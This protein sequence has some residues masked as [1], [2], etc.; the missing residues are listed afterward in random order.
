[1][2]GAD[3]MARQAEVEREAG[4]Y[5]GE[6]KYGDAANLPAGSAGS[7]GGRGGR[8]SAGRAPAT[9]RSP[10]AGGPRKPTDADMGPHNFGGGEGKPAGA[11][12]VGGGLKAGMRGLEATLFQPFVTGRGR[13]AE[14]PGTGLGL[15]IAL[16]WAERHE[17]AIRYE[18]IA[19]EGGARFVVRWPRST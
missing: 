2:L 8:S 7:G 4:R 16:R 18:R 12:G 11:S 3:P 19:K 14:H 9:A 15:A 6:R 13:D 1:M 10:A 17:G 5:G